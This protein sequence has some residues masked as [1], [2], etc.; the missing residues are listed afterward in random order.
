[1]HDHVVGEVLAALGLDVVDR[2]H[3]HALHPH[4]RLLPDR[5]HPL[6]GKLV[7]AGHLEPLALV[8]G[9][10]ADELPEAGARLRVRDRHHERSPAALAGLGPAP[11]PRVDA[12]VQQQGLHAVGEGGRRGGQ[13]D[14][15]QPRPVAA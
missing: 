14:L 2:L 15:G 13:R 4:H 12:E 5:A 11:Q 9:D 8:V 6:A 10:E 1:M 3:P 7:R